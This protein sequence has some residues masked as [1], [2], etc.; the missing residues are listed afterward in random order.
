MTRSRLVAAGQQNFPSVTNRKFIQICGVIGIDMVK[1][2]RFKFTE[3]TKTVAWTQRLLV[4]VE[5]KRIVLAMQDKKLANRG[6]IPP[7]STVLT[8]ESSL[9]FCNRCELY[10]GRICIS[11]LHG[12]LFFE[13]ARHPWI[14]ELSQRNEIVPS[15][16]CV[17]QQ[18]GLVQPIWTDIHM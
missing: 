9:A 1:K 16:T 11:T 6:S 13:I 8:V 7:Q 18:G 12:K 3:L 5:I 17:R 2:Y 4:R 15:V 14:T 10:N